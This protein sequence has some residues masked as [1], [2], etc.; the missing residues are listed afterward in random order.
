M[1]SWIKLSG[2]I[3]VFLTASAVASS[4]LDVKQTDTYSFSEPVVEHFIDV[5]F[6]Y[7]ATAYREFA[8]LFNLCQK[9]PQH[10][11][12]GEGYQSLRTDYEQAKA[13]HQVLIM[14]WE[15]E[16]RSLLLPS[17]GIAQM[18]KELSQLGYTA[19]ST[20][21]EEQ[22]DLV[23]LNKWLVA[24]EFAPTDRIYL[25]HGYLVSTDFLVKRSEIKSS[26]S[27]N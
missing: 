15:P 16:F 21:L 1:K 9:Q 18:K 5:A 8:T 22:D 17:L 20:D 23:E 11:K 10:E 13:N 6:Q 19:D 27:T 14:A 2:F 24:H 12:C 4:T 26:L 3:S 7:K 25:L